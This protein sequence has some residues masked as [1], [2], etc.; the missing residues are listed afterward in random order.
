M[1]RKV[2]EQAPD[3]NPVKTNNS[4]GNIKHLGSTGYVG[5]DTNRKNTSK[6]K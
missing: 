6:L 4:E 5:E 1:I 3:L 2:G